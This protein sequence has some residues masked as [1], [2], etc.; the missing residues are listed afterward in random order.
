[1]A[2]NLEG[3]VVGSVPVIRLRK[4][5]EVE[6]G[7]REALFYLDEEEFTVPKHPSPRVG[8]RFLYLLG[9]E[10]EGQANYFLLTELL[11]LKGYRAL[12]NYKPLTQDQFDQIMD[13]AIK[14]STGQGKGPKQRR[15]RPIQN[16][17]I[18]PTRSSGPRYS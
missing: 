8:L 1:M 9:T 13:L 12:M 2:D 16:G 18:A 6:E 7:E 15:T 17:S 5:A 14:I 4:D 3:Q 11:G 10:G